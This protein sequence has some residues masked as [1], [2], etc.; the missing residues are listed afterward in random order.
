MLLHREIQQFFLR[1]LFPA[2][3]RARRSQSTA[4]ADSSKL[5]RESI[6]LLR[7]KAL[8]HL[9]LRSHV[10]LRASGVDA[11]QQAG[12]KQSEQD[13]RQERA[14]LHSHQSPSSSHKNEKGILLKASAF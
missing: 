4:G 6:A 8:Q 12:G 13:N 7:R 3:A 11:D 9:Q 5:L 1:L 14:R 10:S 2:A